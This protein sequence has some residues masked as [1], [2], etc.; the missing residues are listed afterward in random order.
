MKANT[1]NSKPKRSAF[2]TLIAILLSITL[3][4]SFVANNAIHASANDE[5]GIRYRKIERNAAGTQ[6]LN[7]TNF[8]VDGTRIIAEE[9]T[10]Y[11]LIEYFWDA[12]GPTGMRRNHRYY[13]FV[14]DIFNNIVEIIDQAG[15]SVA[16]YLYDAWGNTAI[17]HNVGNIAHIN[18]FRYRG[19]YMDRGTGFYYL[20]TRFYD[21]RVRRFINADNFMLVPMLA[22][23]MELNMY[24]YA[25][26][27]PVMFIDPTGQIA[28]GAIIGGALKF[29]LGVLVVIGVLYVAC[30][31]LPDSINLGVGDWLR[32]ADWN[33]VGFMGRV[34][35]DTF[36][37]QQGWARRGGAPPGVGADRVINPHG[38]TASWNIPTG[39][40]MMARRRAGKVT[41]PTGVHRG[42]NNPSLTPI[43]N[44]DRI[45]DD[46]WGPGNWRNRKGPAKEHNIIRKYIEWIRGL[47]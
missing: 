14:R 6:V 33:R 41:P 19:K 47:G 38:G 3:A 11:G 1:P 29:L 15:M 39:N 40:I 34:A 12:I 24:A 30:M 20:Q 22:G 42:M 26:N 36:R 35:W 9:S 31:L 10:R 16:R 43:Q 32:H 45:M 18:P 44:A 5:N 7:T 27:N 28:E 13:F 4:F 21:P 2:I 8:F 25:R 37:V 46:R 23:S 17:T